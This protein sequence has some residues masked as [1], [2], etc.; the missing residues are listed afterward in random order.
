M[1]RDEK[2]DNERVKTNGKE[3]GMKGKINRR[4]RAGRQCKSFLVDVF[5]SF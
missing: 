5:M 3:K 4:N 1:K 2:R